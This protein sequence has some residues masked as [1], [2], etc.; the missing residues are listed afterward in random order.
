MGH[1]DF[2]DMHNFPYLFSIFLVLANLLVAHQ[3]SSHLVR[4]F[5]VVLLL[6]NRQIVTSLRAAIRDFH[7]FL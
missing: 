4:H 1:Y 7:Y 3:H 5:P 2:H 6:W